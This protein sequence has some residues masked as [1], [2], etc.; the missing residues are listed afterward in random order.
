MFVSG[1][2]KT[3]ETVVLNLAPKNEPDDSDSLLTASKE[4]HHKK[5]TGHHSEHSRPE[6]P[7]MEQSQNEENELPKNSI[8]EDSPQA[9]DLAPQTQ[10]MMQNLL[11]KKKRSRDQ[12]EE[13]KDL[14]NQE[15]DKS[16]NSDE[17]NVN[18]TRTSSSEPEKKRARDKSEPIEYPTNQNEAANKLLPTPKIIEVVENVQ[19]NN[20]VEPKPCIIPT[21]S[22]QPEK[23]KLTFASSGFASLAN[24]SV[25]PFGSLGMAKLSVFG[26]GVNEGSG[27]EKSVISSNF[28]VSNSGSSSN[29]QLGKEEPTS[30][31][32]SGKMESGL[33]HVAGE[34]KFTSTFS[35]SAFSTNS[36]VRLSSFASPGAEIP[37]F[38]SKEIREFGAPETSAINYESETHNVTKENELGNNKNGENTLVGHDE[39]LTIKKKIDDGEADEVTILQIRAKLFA[40]ESK[41]SGWKERGVGTLKINLPKNSVQYDEKGNPISG[42]YKSSIR[43]GKHNNETNSAQAARLIMRQESTHRV[44]L[45]TFI[46]REMEF[47]EKSA[48]SSA[49]FLFTAF[50]GEKEVKP[51]RLLLKMSELNSK[52]FRSEIQSIKDKL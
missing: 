28:T 40:I 49:Q 8:S 23:T 33:K 12:I 3:K 18:C 35:S 29:D 31:N 48:V 4:I 9:T 6:L 38:K 46:L 39:S 44:I 51:V 11:P 25:S 36:G 43:K 21:L 26:G 17:S 22:D 41:K 13:R 19:D 15:V 2:N 37:T 45:N 24:S 42:S 32:F 5:S 16:E 34:N 52:L 50:E 27:S 7:I 1:E 14:D 20:Q 10:E 30:I 47:E